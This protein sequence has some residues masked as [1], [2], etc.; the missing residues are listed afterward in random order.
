M[1]NTKI[2]I[3]TPLYNKAEYIS[4]TIL[5]VLAQTYQDWEMLVIDNNSTDSGPDR[6]R[7][8]KDPRVALLQCPKQGPSAARNL[9][10]GRAKG[11]WVQFLDADD[12]LEPDHLEKQLKAA[13]E[14]PSADIIACYWKQFEAKEP[15]RVTLYSPSGMGK[16]ISALR[17]YAIAFAPWHINA[18]LVKRPILAPEYYWPEETD[19]Y[20]GE[21][22]PFWFRLITKCAVAYSDNKGAL[23]R[24]HVPG[25]RNPDR[26]PEKWFA[27]LTGLVNSNLDFMKKRSMKLTAGQC[28][29]LMRLYSSIYFSACRGKNADIQLKSI[30]EGGRW[31]KE[32]FR[33]AEKPKFSMWC[34][35]ILGLKLFLDIKRR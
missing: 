19:K 31:L 27:S 7:E 21:D 11:E 3:I 30:K 20:F 5:S 16:P 17:D 35:R 6:V 10:L 26:N 13:K 34:R 12:L 8:F 23:Y 28:E 9:G 25:Y 18:A 33:I 29:N 24:Y 14:N 15:S 32:Y 22:I 4:E 2:S 1:E